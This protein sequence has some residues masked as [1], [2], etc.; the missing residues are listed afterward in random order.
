MI[1]LIILVIVNVVIAYPLIRDYFVNKAHPKTSPMDVQAVRKM[2]MAIW[3]EYF[4]PDNRPPSPKG[5]GGGSKKY[6]HW[7]TCSQ[8]VSGTDYC[9]KCRMAGRD[10]QVPS[11]HQNEANRYTTVNGIR[12]LRPKTV[13]DYA[14]G[15]ATLDNK[16]D[17]V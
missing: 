10:K 8:L 2:E 1:I 7:T 9:Q 4:T 3:G 6:C 12:V 16:G 14:Y 13:P 11:F 17:I 15:T 5:P